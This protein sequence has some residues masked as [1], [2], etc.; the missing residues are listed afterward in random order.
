MVEKCT[1]VVAGRMEE[2]R[3][4]FF[5]SMMVDTEKRRSTSSTT[6]AHRTGTSLL[7]SLGRK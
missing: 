2:A 3:A 6:S 5:S 1:D 4:K 7:P